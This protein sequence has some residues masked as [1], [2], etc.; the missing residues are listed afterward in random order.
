LL[1][2]S[3]GIKIIKLYQQSPKVNVNTCEYMWKSNISGIKQNSI[4]KLQDEKGDHVWRCHLKCIQ[5]QWI[6]KLC[7]WIF[8]FIKF[9]DLDILHIVNYQ[10]ILS[11]CWIPSRK[12][13]L[14]VD[15]MTWC[16]LLHENCVHPLPIFF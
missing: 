14:F 8:K 10:N 1:W 12:K 6:G 15:N 16:I 2:P 9:H 7:V 5:S 4:I 3:W 11:F 13:K